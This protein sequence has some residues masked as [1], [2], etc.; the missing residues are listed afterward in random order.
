MDQRIQYKFFHWG[1][2]LYKTK[3]FPEKIKKIKTLCEKNKKKDYRSE[4]AGLIEH[5][6][7]IDS[8]KLFP[9]I[10]PYL[11]SYSQAYTDYAG[12]IMGTKIELTD[13]WVNY[14]TKFESNPLHS[15]DEDFSFVIYIDVPKKLKQ[16]VKNTVGNTQPGAI[17]FIY[18][19]ENTK[20]TINKYTFIP[21]IGDFFIFPAS[22]NHSVN[23]F[24]SEGER[25]SVSG[26]LKVS[27]EN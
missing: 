18:S 7:Q 11:N 6:Y 25:V 19:L 26:N 24:Q 1:P 14:M 16:E 22:L 17:N 2:F 9:M 8:K 15:H 10:F 12:K 23:H 21:E 4:L 20:H 5:E 13:S 3:L 27:Y